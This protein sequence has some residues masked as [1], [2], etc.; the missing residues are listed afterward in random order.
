MR[1][2][3]EVS[4]RSKTLSMWKSPSNRNWEISPVPAANLVSGVSGKAFG[5]N[6]DITADWPTGISDCNRCLP[7]DE[8]G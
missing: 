7:S 6:P 5:R 1:E 4:T 8:A 2:S 3:S